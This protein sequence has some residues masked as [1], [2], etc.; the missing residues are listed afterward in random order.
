M[1]DAMTTAT[2]PRHDDVV[3]GYAPPGEDRPLAAYGA[4]TATFGAALAAALVTLRASGRQLP[5]R[6]RASDLVLAGI[7]THKVSRLL[8]RDRVT[9]F[10]RAP[11]TRYQEPAGHGEVEEQ[12]RGTGIRLALGELLVCPFCLA[13]WVAAAFAVG[14]VAAPRETRFIAGI[15]VAETL[16]DVLQ[17][18]YGAAE[19]RA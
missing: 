3:N 4:L 11:F 19:D 9:S 15:Y 2:A 7:A 17:L 10:V 14:L 5:E 13:Q 8:A 18:A 12:P 6:P 16:S 1:S